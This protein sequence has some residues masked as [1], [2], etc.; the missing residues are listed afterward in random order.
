MHNTMI[1]RMRRFGLFHV[2]VFIPY[3][4]CIFACRRASRIKTRPLLNP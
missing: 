1:R 2:D 4:G 3:G